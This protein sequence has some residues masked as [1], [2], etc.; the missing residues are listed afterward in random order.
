MYRFL[1]VCHL[2]GLTMF[3]GSIFGHIVASAGGGA[4]GTAGFLFAREQIA[5]ATRALT[6][7]GLLLA[8]VSG[9]ALASYGRLSPVRNRWIAAKAML[10]ALIV[11]NSTVFLAPAGRHL[12]AAAVALSQNQAEVTAAGIEAALNT[13]HIAGAINI[14]LTLAIVSLGVFKPRLTRHPRSAIGVA[15]NPGGAKRP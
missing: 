3:L 6:L 9:I 10:A 1:K 2:I 13:E 15:V 5:L 8:V 12:V 4:P 7:P 11:F 14:V